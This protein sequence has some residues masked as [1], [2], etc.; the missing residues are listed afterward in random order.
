VASRNTSLDANQHILYV[1]H[2]EYDWRQKVTDIKHRLQTLQGDFSGMARLLSVLFAFAALSLF[3]EAYVPLKQL[4]AVLVA[5]DR[6][7]SPAI[8]ERLIA[9]LPAVLLLGTVW[10]GQ[11]LFSHLEGG[12]LLAPVTAQHVRRSGEWMV[13]A[14]VSALVIGEIQH[15]TATGSALLV[16]VAAVGLA[17]R[18][19]AG[20]LDH[21]AVMQ[22]DLDQ[23]V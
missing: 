1:L 15:G 10:Q 3:A 9:L 11:R 16:G 8:G 12:A 19:L 2:K 20:V 6:A 22:A 23:I 14:A 18:S 17:L 13:S 4:G 5:G 7:G 21:A